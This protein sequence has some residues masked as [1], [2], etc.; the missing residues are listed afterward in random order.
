MQQALRASEDRFRSLVQNSQDIITVHDRNGII[1]YESPSVAR[2]FGYA[3]GFFIGKSP[4][5]FIPT[6]DAARVKHAFEDVVARRNSGLSTEYRFSRA[7]G[8][9]VYLEALGSN[10]LDHPGVRGIVITSSASRHAK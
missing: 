5:D 4:F 7:D 8:T 6:E 10:L 3:P 9:F 2:F 1:I